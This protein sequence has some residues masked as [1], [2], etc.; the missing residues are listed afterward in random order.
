MTHTV[1]LCR[2]RNHEKEDDMVDFD[3]LEDAID[4]GRMMMNMYKYRVWIDGKEWMWKDFCLWGFY[5]E[6]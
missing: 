5:R 4:Y 2:Y 3:T 1:E 6:E